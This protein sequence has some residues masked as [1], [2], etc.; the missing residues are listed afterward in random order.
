MFFIG[1]IILR[2]N[3]FL[4]DSIVIVEW[5]VSRINS[6]II[7]IYLLVDWISRLFIGLVLIITSIVV[8]YRVEYMRGD[9]FIRR[10]LFLVTI[11]VISILLIIL[12]PSLIRILLDWDLLGLVSYCLIIYYQNY[13]FYSRILGW[14]YEVFFESYVL[15]Y[16]FITLLL[17][18]FLLLFW[19]VFMELA[20][21]LP[22]RKT[23][24]AFL[25]RL[26]HYGLYS[27]STR[28]FGLGILCIRV[29]LSANC[30][31]NI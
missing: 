24:A 13:R 9:K 1:F 27:P 21:L 15:L 7:E 22:C 6:L 30:Y 18:F 31:C 29:L 2:I 12:R 20:L 11:F 25:E 8:L 3:L 10:F 4:I 28:M 17:L 26:L 5:L 23:P 14:F 19:M 16:R